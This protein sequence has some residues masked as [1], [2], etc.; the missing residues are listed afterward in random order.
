MRRTRSNGSVHLIVIIVILALVAVVSIY[1]IIDNNKEYP[2]QT[3]DLSKQ[4]CEV[5]AFTNDVVNI[6]EIEK[7][8]PPGLIIGGH[9]KTHSY[10]NFIPK[11]VKIHAPV[12]IV[13][14][15]G[16]KYTHG[17][18]KVQYTL[19]FNG[20][21]RLVIMFDHMSDP[22]DEIKKQFSG[23]PQTDTRSK[24]LDPI[25]FSAGE[26]I[27]ETDGNGVQ[28]QF[29]FG[30]Y[31]LDIQSNVINLEKFKE[32]KDNPSIKYQNAICP[33]DEYSEEKR[34]TYYELF[35]VLNEDPIPKY[36]CSY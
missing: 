26:V 30:V 5:G 3:A 14:T 33:Y 35:S 32:W 20:P 15:H 17:N 12:E 18:D 34:A 1:L 8:I 4:D 22:I 28:K 11:T 24:K 23:P 6:D 16:A 31:D 29:D 9:F 21:C 27:G 25:T 13:L 36:Y 2:S 10:I 19:Q 7:I